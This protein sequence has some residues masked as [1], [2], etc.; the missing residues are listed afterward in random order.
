MSEVFD[1]SGYGLTLDLWFKQ[2][3]NFWCTD[4]LVGP[5][6]AVIWLECAQE[7]MRG[8]ELDTEGEEL[9]EFLCKKEQYRVDW[10]GCTKLYI[11]CIESI[12]SR[13]VNFGECWG[14]W[15]WIGEGRKLYVY[16][17]TLFEGEEVKM[18][19]TFVKRINIQATL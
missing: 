19:N 18:Y 6:G 4:C 3:G 10:R 2:S 11:K 16:Q 15:S 7:K 13:K 5:V 12:K 1:L 9:E 8:E 17:S 14:Q